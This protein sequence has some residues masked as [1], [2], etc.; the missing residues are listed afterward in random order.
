LNIEGA[1]LDE[2]IENIFNKVIAEKNLSIG[3]Q[4]V[5]QVQK[6]LECQTEK[7]LPLS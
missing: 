5:I 7:N 3:K 6:V 4:M 2:R 1:V